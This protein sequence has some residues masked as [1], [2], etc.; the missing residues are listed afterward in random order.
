MEIILWRHAEAEDGPL[1]GNDAARALT[2]R[3]HKQAAK[4]AAWLS[5]RLPGD[6]RVLVSPATRTQETAAALRRPFTTSAA[7][8]VGATADDVLAEAGWPRG[9]RVILIV[10]HQPT[11]GRVA[12]RLICGDVN[13]WSVKK[14]AIVWI[15]RRADGAREPF[16]RAALAPDLL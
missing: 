15:A 13:G 1:G 11:L 8:A 9:D 10:G 6:C 3:G 2:R 7:L 5:E 12:A 4:M 14:G 16:L